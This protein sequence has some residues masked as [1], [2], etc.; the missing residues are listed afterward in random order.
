M[1]QIDNSLSYRDVEDV[2]N[3]II[4]LYNKYKIRFFHFN[5]ATFEGVGEKGKERMEKLCNLLISYPIKFSFRCFVRAGS[6]VNEED[7]K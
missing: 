7:E 1:P 3:E 2:F 5:D 4:Y 6:F